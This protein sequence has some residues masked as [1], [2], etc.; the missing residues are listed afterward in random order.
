MER[1]DEGLNTGFRQDDET[2]ILS[3]M[4]SVVVHP[5]K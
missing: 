2:R 1:Y 3:K 5:R 4:G